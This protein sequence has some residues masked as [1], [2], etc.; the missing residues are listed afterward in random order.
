MPFV[1]FLI[2]PNT[3]LGPWSQSPCSFPR[4]AP[5]AP[6]HAD[7]GDVLSHRFRVGCLDAQSVRAK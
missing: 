5:A 7:E 3:S 1:V 4:K 6:G 2:V